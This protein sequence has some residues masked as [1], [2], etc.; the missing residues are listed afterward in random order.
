M[1]RLQDVLT[2]QGDDLIG[3]RLEVATGISADGR[4]IVGYG[5]GPT[6]QTET[7]VATL[8]TPV[9]EPSALCLFGL[10]TVVLLD[11]G[12]RRRRPR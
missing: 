9:P 4:T 1:R 5:Q 10:G 8:A 7:W 11:Y 6:G 12:W 3:W 2:Q